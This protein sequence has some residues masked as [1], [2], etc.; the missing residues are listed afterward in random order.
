MILDESLRLWPTAPA[1]NLEVKEDTV[2]A[3]K[4][5]LKKKGIG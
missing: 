4:Y 5:D 1:F 2:L 3:G